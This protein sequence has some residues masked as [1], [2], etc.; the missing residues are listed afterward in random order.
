MYVVWFFYSHSALVFWKLTMFCST[1]KT[2]LNTFFD[3]CSYLTTMC[4]NLCRVRAYTLQ[5]LSC[6]LKISPDS[7]LIKKYYSC[8]CWSLFTLTGVVSGIPDPA[9]F[10]YTLYL[11]T[12]TMLWKT[13]YCNRNWKDLTKAQYPNV[14]DSWTRTRLL[15]V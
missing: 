10:Y 5:A 7:D 6:S 9:H 13:S 11:Q 15:E 1:Y 2:P 3:S 12:P 4:D 14:L 8:L